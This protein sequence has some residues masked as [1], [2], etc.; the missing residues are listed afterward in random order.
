MK[1]F[2]SP[3]TPSNPADPSFYFSPFSV[4]PKGGPHPATPRRCRVPVLGL[5]GPRAAPA[6]TRARTQVGEVT[7]GV[8][9][10]EV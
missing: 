2:L 3:D 1:I 7:P 4:A 9:T 5:A 8:G 6:D 10:D